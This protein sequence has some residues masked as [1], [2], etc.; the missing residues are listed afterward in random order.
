MSFYVVVPA[1]YA[2]TRLPG[3][4]LADLAGKP[5]VA[6]VAERCQRSAAEQ[7]LVATDD[8]RIADALEGE[9]VRV[10][11]TRDDHPSG[12]DR[13]QEVAEQ[14]GLADDDI[15]VN[16]QGDEPLIPSAVIDQ[17]AAN[18]ADNPDCQMATLCE[19]IE[20]GDD[21]FNP[22]VVKV[23]FDQT[24]RALYFSRAPIPWH[25]DAF[26]D[27]GR[28][29]SGGQWWRHI[30]IYAYRVA[31]LH[32]YVQ[33]PPAELEKLESLEQLRAMANGIAIHVAPACEPVPGG[34]DTP[35]DLARLQAYLETQ[36]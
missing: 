2:S 19:P 8:T 24:G 3:K 16:V 20:Q 27:G 18:L 23:V 29:I 34:V 22:N 13:L 11:M 30:G 25:R 33:W 26:A 9:S 21:L 1:R 5:M 36:S 10:V 15:I 28:D 32:R 7:V 4:P 31:L 17:V 35:E 14:L 12:T 6:R